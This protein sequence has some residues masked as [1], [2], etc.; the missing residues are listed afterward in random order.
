MITGWGVHHIDTAH[1]G[2]NTEHTG[3]IEAECVH[4]DFPKTGLWNVHGPFEV[5]MKYANGVEM[6]INDTYQNGIKFEGT[7]GWVFCARTPDKV[8]S[9][10]PSTAFVT[11]N[12]YFTASDPALLT[13][14][15]GP[16]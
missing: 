8:T 12:N 1:W 4:V 7:K 5:R 10:D 14:A 11:N 3:P 16:N 13:H 15:T 2:M 6:V 9:T